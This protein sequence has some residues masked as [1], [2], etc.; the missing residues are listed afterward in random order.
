ML[1]I[2]S[3]SSFSEP[4]ATPMKPAMLFPPPIRRPGF[5]RAD[6]VR[7]AALQD[8]R[9]A[10]FRRHAK[11]HDR[12]T[13][14]ALFVLWPLIAGLIAGRL[15]WR[16]GH[17]VE[18]ESGKGRLRQWAEQMQ[19]S[20]RWLMLPHHYYMFELYRPGQ[21]EKA[22]DY[23]LRGQT[24][25]GVYPLFKNKLM[26]NFP[27][28][29]FKDKTAFAEL[30]QQRQLATAA[31]IVSGDSAGNINWGDSATELPKADLFLK[32]RTGQGGRGAQKWRF[33][34]GSW[35][36]D[37]TVLDQAGLLAH[38]GNLSR[39]EPMLVQPCIVNHPDIIDLS[40]DALATVRLVTI[41]DMDESPK[42]IAAA[43]RMPASLIS[44]VDNFHAGGI[45]AA[46]AIDSG[47][48][49][50]ATDIGLGADSAWHPAHPLTGAVIEGRILPFWE[51]AKRLATDAHHAFINRVVVGWDIAITASGPV[52]IEANGF[53]DL[54]IIQ[55]TSRAPLADSELGHLLAYHLDRLKRAYDAAGI[56]PMDG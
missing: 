1:A 16:L 29:P 8:E 50:S 22:Q 3:S 35:H 43:F 31:T 37:G 5:G 7:V 19:V 13:L 54:D 21:L 20:L 39:R 12:A 24:K 2:S 17:R 48:L 25:E 32:P 45:A 34:E 36:R 53:P 56:R 14:L 9:A 42:A 4:A 30:C 26:R 44:V 51:Q 49:G 23:V 55:R 27:D 18:R 40:V 28:H 6:N 33:R 15:A 47:R 52:L 10:R 46:V 41:L 38:V 11:P